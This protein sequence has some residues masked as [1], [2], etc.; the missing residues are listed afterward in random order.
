MD[1]AVILAA[2]LGKRMR[3]DD[4]AARLTQQQSDV[5][6]TGL[7]AMIPLGR[8]FLD[9]VISA[10]ADAGFQRLCLVVG[11]DHNLITDYYN[12]LNP[13]R[14]KIDFAIQTQP[15]GTADAVT[16]A[17]NFVAGDEFSV[18]NSDNY[19]PPQ[20]LAALRQLDEPG[21][22][23]FELDALLR[24]ANISKNRIHNFAVVIGDQNGCL[25]NIIE[26]PPP[27]LLAQA[28]KPLCVSMNCWRFNSSIFPA[29]RAILPSKRGELELP[30]AVQYAIKSLHQSFRLVPMKL[31]V[32]DL[33]GRRDIESVAACLA[34]VEV[35]L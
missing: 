32:L 2:G 17:E 4:Q 5:A 18:I 23:G 8:P 28:Q 14:V 13:S 20:A 19:Y 11:P 3:R 29:C 27:E 12:R 34:H 15:R 10:L 26:K 31:P 25:S 35:S 21:L 1:K 24:D 6:K 22:I 16:A 9:Y 30:D 33:T 7:K